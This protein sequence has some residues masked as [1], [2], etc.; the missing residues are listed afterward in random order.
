MKGGA[1]APPFPLKCSEFFQVFLRFAKLVG[2]FPPEANKNL[3]DRADAE[4]LLEVFF[5]K[6][7]DDKN[8][9]LLVVVTKLQV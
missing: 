7:L 5:G 8:M 3:K 2:M 9:W 4:T 1:S 6:S